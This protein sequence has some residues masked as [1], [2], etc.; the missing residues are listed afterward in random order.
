MLVAGMSLAL[1]NIFTAPF[2]ARHEKSK[3]MFFSF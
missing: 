1:F 3:E 2:I